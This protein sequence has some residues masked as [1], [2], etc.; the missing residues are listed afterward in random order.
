M[1]GEVV[2]LGVVLVVGGVEGEVAV[3]VVGKGFSFRKVVLSKPKLV[4]KKMK[5]EKEN[6][7]QIIYVSSHSPSDYSRRRIVGDV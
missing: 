6:N 1:E 3:L 4:S 7:S 5:K 2:F